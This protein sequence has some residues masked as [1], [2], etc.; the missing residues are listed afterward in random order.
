M[1]TPAAMILVFTQSEARA[2]RAFGGVAIVFALSFTKPP[3]GNRLIVNSQ[4]GFRLTFIQ[5]RREEN[6]EFRLRRHCGGRR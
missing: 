4:P 5:T 2:E 3:S 6:R 1:S